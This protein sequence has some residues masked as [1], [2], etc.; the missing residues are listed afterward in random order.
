MLETDVT[1][2]PLSA[3]R[4]RLLEIWRRAAESCGV[5]LDAW[6]TAGDANARSRCYSAYCAALNREERAAIA[7][8]A[9]CS[10]QDDID[11]VE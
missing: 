5:A 10:K 9:A 3:L 2:A 7:L 1:L 6:R 8:A 11:F 4:P